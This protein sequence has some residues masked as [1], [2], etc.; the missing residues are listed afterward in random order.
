MA[1]AEYHSTLKKN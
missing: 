1:M